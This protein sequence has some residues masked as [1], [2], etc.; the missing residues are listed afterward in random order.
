MLNTPLLAGLGGFIRKD[1]ALS[2]KRVRDA[3]SPL[4][5]LCNYF[6]KLVRAN[7]KGGVKAQNRQIGGSEFS[8]IVGG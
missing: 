1:L 8:G 6:P 2:E 7:Y 4:S 5:P 3:N